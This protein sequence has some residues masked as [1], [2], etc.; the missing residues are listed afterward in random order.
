MRT[1]CENAFIRVYA[2]GTHQ[3]NNFRDA[4]NQAKEVAVNLPGGEMLTEEQD[5]VIE[6]LIKLRDQKR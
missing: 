6:M 5:E 3:T 1:Y 2:L 4:V